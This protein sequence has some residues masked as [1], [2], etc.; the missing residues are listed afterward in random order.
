[1]FHFNQNVEQM[2]SLKS[3]IRDLPNDIKHPGKRSKNEQRWQ[4]GGRVGRGIVRSPVNQIPSDR[5]IL[6]LLY[7]FTKIKR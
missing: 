1:M 6:L 2:Q 4:A 3:P 5:N 7:I